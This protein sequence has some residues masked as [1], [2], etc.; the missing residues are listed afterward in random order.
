M[1]LGGPYGGEKKSFLCRSSILCKPLAL[2][3]ETIRRAEKIKPMFSVSEDFPKFLIGQTQE[4]EYRVCV[5]REARY[6][7]ACFCRSL[8]R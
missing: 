1:V 5:L 8:P 4:C 6:W 7:W 2:G 3:F